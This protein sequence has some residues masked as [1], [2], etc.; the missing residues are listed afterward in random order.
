MRLRD[1]I[2]HR[3]LMSQVVQVVSLLLVLLV[4]GGYLIRWILVDDLRQIS[5]A[6]TQGIGGKVETLTL[7]AEKAATSLARALARLDAKTNA[8][9]IPAAGFDRNAIIAALEQS[10]DGVAGIESVRF[11]SESGR[12]CVCLNKNGQAS[13][14]AAGF[15]RSDWFLMAK[16][17]EVALWAVSVNEDPDGVPV[18]IYSVPVRRQDGQALG[19]AIATVAVAQLRDVM[20]GHPDEIPHNSLLLTRSGRIVAST[21]ALPR[22]NET[23]FSLAETAPPAFRQEL[24]EIY[25]QVLRERAGSIRLPLSP[26]DRQ[27][28]WSGYA[29]VGSGD[30]VL[31]AVFPQQAFLAQANRILMWFLLMALVTILLVAGIIYLNAI[32]II[33]PLMQLEEAIR[34]FP[35]HPAVPMPSLPGDNEISRLGR[36]FEGMRRRL[37]SHISNLEDTSTAK[38]KLEGEVVAAQSIQMGLLPRKFPECP[39]YAI[40]AAI[41][42]ANGIGGDIYDFFQADK[43]H[44][45]LFIGDVSGEGIP[46]ALFMAVCRTIFRDTCRDGL[47]SPSTIFSRV[48]DALTEYNERQLFV[49]AFCAVIDL[50]NGDCWYASAGHCPPLVIRQEGTVERLDTAQNI[51]LGVFPGFRFTEGWIAIK[52]EDILC[53]FTD[54]VTE[55]RAAGR[56]ELFGESRLMTLLLETRHEGLDDVVSRILASIAAY[57]SGMAQSDDI[58]IMLLRFNQLLPPDALET[59]AIMHQPVG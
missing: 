34:R 28:C 18:M 19:I 35:E 47:R 17:A 10:I 15:E 25:Q 2:S 21:D 20:V 46:A 55:A 31:M 11:A 12:L 1:S 36:S 51:V 16:G 45:C 33:R 49:T 53:L 37:Q 59:P 39:E 40:R 48:N 7:A 52:P 5:L 54:G 32:A 42:P 41:R 26:P 3:L 22:L 29:A 27:A 23:V 43:N 38:T 44:L 6:H 4:V 30:L 14:A 57:T 50:R 24:R 9:E 13:D 8:P 58:A 56:D